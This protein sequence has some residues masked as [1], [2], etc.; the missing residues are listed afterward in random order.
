[1]I[2]DQVDLLE[3]LEPLA[4]SKHSKGLL[5]LN[6]DVLFKIQNG[7]CTKQTWHLKLDGWKTILSFWGP[8]Y[9]QLLTVSFRE[10][11]HGPILHGHLQD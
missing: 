8:A 6:V 1:M 9:V 2:S 5:L 11:I 10:C 4:V 3:M 7:K